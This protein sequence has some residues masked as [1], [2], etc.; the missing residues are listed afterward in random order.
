MN[1]SIRNLRQEKGISL[2]QFADLMGIDKLEAISIEADD[3]SGI[4]DV[5]TRQQAASVL[6]D[7]T[8]VPE[9]IDIED[10]AINTNLWV[11]GLSGHL[12]ND[13]V[14]DPALTDGA[15]S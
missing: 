14:N 12:D 2:Q 7:P 6:N 11:L 15:C 13:H 10:G 4:L 1:T 8:V 3:I 5:E 9:P